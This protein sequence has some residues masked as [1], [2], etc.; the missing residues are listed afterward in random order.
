MPG[1]NIPFWKTK[2][3]NTI[4]RDMRSTIELEKMKWNVI[5]VWECQTKKHDLLIK[6]LQEKI[7]HG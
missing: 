5:V 6:S 4:R 7:T 3:E 1:S 2:F